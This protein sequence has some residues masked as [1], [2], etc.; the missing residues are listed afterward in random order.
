MHDPTTS[1][2]TEDRT[3][4]RDI[5]LLQWELNQVLEKHGSLDLV[6]RVRRLRELSRRRRRGD[7]DAG[8]EMAAEMAVTE[9]DDL[10]QIIRVQGCYL[11]LVNLAE[12]RQRLRVLRAREATRYPLSR[13]ESAG[14][15]IDVLHSL[16]W[17]PEQVQ[18]LLDLLQV[19]PVFTAHPTEAKRATI[20]QALRRVRQELRDL[21]RP[22]LSRHDRESLLV[23]FQSDLA[24]L[25]ETD[26]VRPRRPTVLEEVHRNMAIVAT[27]WEV[28]PRLYFDLRTALRRNYGDYP[29]RLP[30]LLRFGT[31]IGGD[32][33]GN[34]FVT[35]AITRQT[36]VELRQEALQRHLA[37][38]RDLASQLS[39]SDRYHPINTALAEAIRTARQRW[40]VV[41]PA[42]TACHPHEP[43]RHWLAVIRHRLQAAAA[44]GPDQVPRGLAYRNS[45]EL[46]RDVLLIYENL[47]AGGHIGLAEGPVQEWLARI[48][49]LGF[50][51]AELDIREESG[52]LRSVVAELARG[53]G[54]CPDFLGLDEPEK[55][56]FLLRPLDRNAVD[57]LDHSALSPE[58]LET[59]DLM[60][61][62]QRAASAWGRR[63]LGAMIV[64]MTHYPSDVLTLVWLNRLGAIVEGLL[65]TPLP[66]VPLFETISDL[67]GAD[68]TLREMLEHPDY[69]G[70]LRE[71]DGEQVCMI[72]Y[73]DSVKDGGYITA[74][75]QLYDAQRRLSA[76]ADEFRVKIVF[77]HG[78]GGALGRGGGPAA[79][80]VLSLPVDSVRGRLR[81]TEQGEVVAERYGDAPVAHRHL[82]QL[83]WAT[84][85]VS[86]EV[87]EPPRDQWTQRLADAARIGYR[88]YREL[89][90]DPAFS[91][92][93]RHATP[94]DVIE[95]LPIGSR[96]S[97][98]AQH[99]QL[100]QLRAIPY[101]FAWTQS[102]HLLTGFYGLGSGLTAVAEGDWSQ[103][104]EMHERWPFFRALVDNAELALAKAEPEIVARYVELMPQ[105]E[106]AQRIRLRIEGEYRKTRDA[107]L[108]I[109]QR[110]QLLDNT[111][112]L[113]HS[114]AMRNPDVDI[115][116]FAQIELLRRRAMAAGSDA[117]IEELL[118]S[119]VQ[120]ISAGM[121]T[122]G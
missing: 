39:V 29:F 107:I 90:E 60:R 47:L 24:C 115:L 59:L 48:D 99:G 42:I 35:A 96:P 78:R 121:R 2:T 79:R 84:M 15:A 36:L 1:S 51:I 117:D 83:T 93:F 101:T 13:H 116:N 26:S 19:S 97:R 20:R 27:L 118:R 30:R 14:A 53:T 80:A 111:P 46:V 28:I 105:R 75:W 103:L 9:L 21:D 100:D 81:M 12:D 110:T 40:P 122:T 106:D 49:V 76:L 57:H 32:R 114:I 86:S 77:F 38:C 70:S 113:Q 65:Y 120:A 98:R 108:R 64:S 25:W 95:S 33:D 92:Y 7:A 22:D 72:G 73:S 69:L 5:R 89:V 119:S 74:N 16:D 50:H 58:S 56:A 54:L 18:S 43:Y 31:W 34:P 66:A 68:K 3:F 109:A 102:R 112:W 17:T 67:D 23:H 8:D 94:I 11:D 37:A 91:A 55:Q 82:E 88:A 61:L 104:R 52:R 4:R 10:H 87:A 44:I 41:E 62:M 71:N 63:P 85:L 6:E 45:R